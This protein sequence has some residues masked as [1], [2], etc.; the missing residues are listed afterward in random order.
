MPGSTV[1]Q[2][3]VDY[4]PVL[5]LDGGPGLRRAVAALRYADRKTATA[6][7]AGQAPGWALG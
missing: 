7:Q 2:H 1:A 6:A 3:L 5:G 4:E